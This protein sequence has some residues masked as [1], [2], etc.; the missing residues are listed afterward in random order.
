MAIALCA[1]L[2]PCPVLAGAAAAY[3]EGLEDLPLMPGLAAVPGA[4]I[5]FDKPSG[6][7]VEAYATGRLSRASIYEFYRESLADLGWSQAGPG[8]FV[9]DGEK[10]ELEVLG[11]DG[12]VVVRYSLSPD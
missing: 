10:L 6:R 3:V 8:S 9:R 12:D 7:I 5:A 2:L 4:G 1:H 11:K